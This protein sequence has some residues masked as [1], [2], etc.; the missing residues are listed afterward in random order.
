LPEIPMKEKKRGTKR[1]IRRDR[2]KPKPKK[3]CLRNIKRGRYGEKNQVRKTEKKS[4]TKRT[5]KGNRS[6]L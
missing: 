6:L 5:S 4:G 2:K 3:V 1:K